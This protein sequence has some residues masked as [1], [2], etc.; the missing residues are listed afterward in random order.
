M[1]E[2]GYRLTRCIYEPQIHDEI[3]EELLSYGGGHVNYCGTSESEYAASVDMAL[4]KFME[5]FTA[6]APALKHPSFAEERE[7]RLILHDR[8]N[9]PG[10]MFRAGRSILIPYREFKLTSS[11]RPQLTFA[12]GYVGPT[13]HMALAI[14]AVE[15]LLVSN[16]VAHG[17]ISASRAPYRAW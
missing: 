8:T 12:E 14:S 7:W 4:T 9:A 15:D 11:P 2:Q 17:S 5:A 3:V 13:P 1:L 6:I 16:G 10:L